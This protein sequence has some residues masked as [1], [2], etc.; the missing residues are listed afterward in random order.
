VRWRVRD[1]D[2]IRHGLRDYVVEHRS[3][4]G[5]ITGDDLLRFFTV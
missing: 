4:T 3:S 1:C 2:A 5:P